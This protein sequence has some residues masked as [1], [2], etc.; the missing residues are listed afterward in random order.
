[1]LVFIHIWTTL[2]DNLQHVQKVVFSASPCFQASYILEIYSTVLFYLGI[3]IVLC[4]YD[5]SFS[6][7]ENSYVICSIEAF[8]SCNNRKFFCACVV[9]IYINCYVLF[10]WH[11]I[12]KIVVCYF[13][14]WNIKFCSVLQF[15]YWHSFLRVAGGRKFLP[16]LACTKSVGTQGQPHSTKQVPSPPLSPLSPMSPPRL[17]PCPLPLPPGPPP[18]FHPPAPSTPSAPPPSL[19]TGPSPL[20]CI[21]PLTPSSCVAS[22][23]QR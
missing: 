23:Y 13:I 3:T 19:R 22:S 9:W 2:F 20:L 4:C 5:C 7:I 11:G 8:V 1:M 6:M 18:S 12:S 10:Y 17:P 15:R 21:Y 16:N 14:A